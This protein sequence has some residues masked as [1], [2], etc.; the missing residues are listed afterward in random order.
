MKVR[1][2]TAFIRQTRAAQAAANADNSCTICREQLL[3][4]DQLR[5]LPCL[6]KYHVKC[7]DKWLARSRTCPICKFDIL[8]EAGGAQLRNAERRMASEEQ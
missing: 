3:I 1:E 6:H 4:G 2:A 8:D 5:L 7:V